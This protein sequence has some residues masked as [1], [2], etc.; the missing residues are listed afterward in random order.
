MGYQ[1]AHLLAS[2]ILNKIAQ[3]PGSPGPGQGQN[4]IHGSVIIPRSPGWLQRMNKK[5]WCA[6][7]GKKLQQA[8]CGHDH[9]LPLPCST[10]HPPLDASIDTMHQ[11]WPEESGPSSAD[12]A[13]ASTPANSASANFVR[14]GKTVVSGCQ[15]NRSQLGHG[16]IALTEE[17]DEPLC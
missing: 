10:N 17:C 16:G 11:Q 3:W 1:A 6:S 15:S 9:C 5:G 12:E 13:T 2:G 7:G 4:R 8:F 14:T